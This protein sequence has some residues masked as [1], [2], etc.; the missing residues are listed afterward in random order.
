MELQEIILPVGAAIASFAVAAGYAMWVGRQKAGTKEMVDISDAVKV[1]A[2]AFIR[3]EMKII[4]PIA[5]GLSVVIGYF[6][7]LSNGIAFAVGA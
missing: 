1:G 7:G 6:I 4:I 2:S 5:I 3:R